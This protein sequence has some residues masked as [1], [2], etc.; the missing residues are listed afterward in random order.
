MRRAIP[1]TRAV[2]FWRTTFLRCIIGAPRSAYTDGNARAT[3]RP[4]HRFRPVLSL[5]VAA[6]CFRRRTGRAEPEFL[7]T[8]DSNHARGTEACKGTVGA[9]RIRSGLRAEYAGLPVPPSGPDT[10]GA[11]RLQSGAGDRA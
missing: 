8:A 2:P 5:R 4:A 11:G 9:E 10:K 7:R 1:V 3:I 6:D